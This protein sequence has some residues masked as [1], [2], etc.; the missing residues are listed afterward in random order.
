MEPNEAL[1]PIAEVMRLTGIKSRTSIYSL[2]E[3]DGRFPRPV[4][5]GT[6]GTRFRRSEL[7]AWI[8]SLPY[9]DGGGRLL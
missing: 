6:R 7:Q 1:L 2:I 4:K 3:T 9:K 8:K 5:F